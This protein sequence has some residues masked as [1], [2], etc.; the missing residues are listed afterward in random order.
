MNKFLISTILFITTFILLSNCTRDQLAQSQVDCD[1]SVTYNTMIKPIID[2]S[3]SYSGCHD[4]GAGIG[5][6]NYTRYD[7]MLKHLNSGSF[8]S[9]TI[10]QRD[11]PSLGMPPDMSVYE[12]TLKDDL[13]PEELEIMTC[14]LDNGFPE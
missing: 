1:E 6:A 5:P 13:T 10:D 2:N 14:W 7:G 8:R 3:C 4:G 12:E 9:R 11:S